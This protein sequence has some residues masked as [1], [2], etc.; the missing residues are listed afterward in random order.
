MG[1]SSILDGAR[2]VMVAVTLLS[3]LSPQQS[4]VAELSVED[5]Q[6]LLDVHNYHRASVNAADMNQIVSTFYSN[7]GQCLGTFADSYECDCGLQLI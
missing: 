5:K 2:F 3:G 1:S 7:C 4:A 6:L